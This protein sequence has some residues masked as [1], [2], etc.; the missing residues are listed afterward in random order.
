MKQ[1]LV[2]FKGGTVSVQTSGFTGASC[3]SETLELEQ[4]LGIEGGVDQKTPEFYQRQ[5]APAT[6]KAGR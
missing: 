5:Q 6:Q 2:T 1:I 3:L 4:A